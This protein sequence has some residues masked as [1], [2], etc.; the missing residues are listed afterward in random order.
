MNG[1]GD[2]VPG[3]FRFRTKKKD[4]EYKSESVRLKR[5]D[6]YKFLSFENKTGRTFSKKIP[7]I[8]KT[9]NATVEARINATP[10]IRKSNLRAERDIV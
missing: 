3:S 5:T 6:S 8:S 2:D 10:L 9:K 1:D 7:K 4:P